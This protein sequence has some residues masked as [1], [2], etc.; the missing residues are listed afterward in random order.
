MPVSCCP[1][2]RWCRRPIITVPSCVSPGMAFV[3][4]QK[5]ALVEGN[6]HCC[7]PL[8][9]PQPGNAPASGATPHRPRCQMRAALD[10]SVKA[11]ANRR[12]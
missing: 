6:S 11:A 12:A 9:P 3:L 5:A 10:H 8:R 7:R 1:L 2:W 4:V